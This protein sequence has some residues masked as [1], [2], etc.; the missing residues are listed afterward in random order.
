MEPME[1]GGEWWLPETPDV[2]VSG[3]LRVDD[4]GS[5]QL[6][7]I[8]E[9]R[10]HLQEAERHERPDGTVE[11]LFSEDSLHSSGK[12]PRV[13]GQVGTKEYT[14]EDGFRIR[15]NTNLLGGLASETI[16]FSQVLRGVW[17]QTG[18]ELAFDRVSVS[19]QWLT[20]WVGDGG[21]EETHE[22]V[23]GWP[24]S[25]ALRGSQVPNRRVHLGGGLTVHLRHRIGLA[26]DGITS[27]RLTQQFVF[28]TRSTSLLQLESLMTT[29]ARLQALVS[30]GTGRTAGFDELVLNHP[31]L[32]QGPP[33]KPRQF[34]RSIDYL[35]QWSARDV[36]PRPP[37]RHDMPFTLND[38]GGMA[39]V[40]RW[41]QVAER[42]H[43]QLDQVMAT[44]YDG[45][46]VS[47]RLLNR[48]AALEGFHKLRA[49]PNLSLKQRLIQCAVV[50]GTPFQ[51]LV[52]DVAKW[53]D[54]A[55][56]ARNDIGHG[57][58][59]GGFEAAN[60]LFVADAAYWLF[61][62]CLLRDMDAPEVVFTRITETPTY[63]WLKRNLAD[64]LP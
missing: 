31:D 50:A 18:D 19:M 64:A 16:M 32:T 24:V 20:H 3:V 7:L 13:L 42:Y 36:D 34:R 27:R 39:A 35:A 30:I 53:A 21:I 8:G 2:K 54:V 55:K 43:H 56:R 22:W 11:F 62:L 61:V 59:P 57:S 15:H 41:L 58:G 25:F 12:Y 5:S 29:A 23:E 47:D 49:A 38:L 1:E 60:T 9:L 6:S 28:E 37:A 48:V 51:D 10:S 52:P 33:S 63:R 17:L 14:L 26:G 44:R 40:G 46:M 4:R 45:G